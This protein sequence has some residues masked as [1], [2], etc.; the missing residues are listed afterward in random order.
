MAH[1]QSHPFRHAVCARVRP[2]C[3]ANSDSTNV[4]TLNEIIAPL[5]LAEIGRQAGNV[6]RERGEESR[7][8]QGV[9]LEKKFRMCGPLR[10]ARGAKVEISYL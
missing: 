6:R 2:V 10:G 3:V 7:H 4:S 9:E 1:T 5:F 8:G